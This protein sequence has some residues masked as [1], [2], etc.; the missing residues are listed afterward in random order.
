M[1][2]FRANK[3]SGGRPALFALALHFYLAFGHIQPEDIYNP[4]EIALPGATSIVLPAA[5]ALR[6]IPADQILGHS[7]ESCPICEAMYLLGV[8]FTPDRPRILP[9]PRAWRRLE[10]LAAIAAIAIDA[11]RAPFQSRAPPSI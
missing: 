1:G 3:G 11:R 4:A 8:W 10:P 5:E 6:A 9:R 2:W 7:D